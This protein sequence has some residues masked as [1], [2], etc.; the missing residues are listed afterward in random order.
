M[1]ARKMAGIRV[2][3]V[4][5]WPDT[6]FVLLEAA[7]GAGKKSN[8]LRGTRPGAPFFCGRA[9]PALNVVKDPIAGPPI[10]GI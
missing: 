5:W 3:M 4:I 1:I 8:I 2:R 6:F 9:L 10:W 7:P